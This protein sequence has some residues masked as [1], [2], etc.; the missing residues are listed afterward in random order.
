MG[1]MVGNMQT[2]IRKTSSDILLFALK[3]A[4]GLVIGLTLGLI[5][6]EVLGKAEG[7]NV[8]AFVFV[9]L[10]TTGAF[11]RIAKTWG[12]TAVLVFDLVSVLAGMILKLYIMVA[13]GL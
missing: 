11:M 12:L 5:M 6:Q 10:V 7:E 3:L 9:I 2:H 13:P 1:E 8:I 4:S